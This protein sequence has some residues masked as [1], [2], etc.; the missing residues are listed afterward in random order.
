LPFRCRG[1]RRESAVAQLST[2]GGMTFTQTMKTIKQAITYAIIY[3]LILA[4]V[5]G[6]F[7]HFALSN[8]GNTN[9]I[10]AIVF[11][12]HFPALYLF[13]LLHRFVDFPFFSSFWLQM[14]LVGV[15]QW[16]LLCLGFL[17][18]SKRLRGKNAA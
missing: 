8:P 11:Y 3:E 6:A 5:Y 4:C 13:A 12:L 17:F 18:L 16:F 14:F 1:S 7:G 15:V 9:L 10:G 2:L